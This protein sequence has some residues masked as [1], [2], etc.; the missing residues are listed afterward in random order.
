[1]NLISKCYI[2]RTKGIAFYGFGITKSELSS[3]A[4]LQVSDKELHFFFCDAFVYVC[5]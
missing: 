4:A 3:I 2:L 5:F 1:M